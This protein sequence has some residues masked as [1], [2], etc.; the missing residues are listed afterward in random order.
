MHAFARAGTTNNVDMNRNV[1]KICKKILGP[2]SS[3]WMLGEK[4]LKRTNAKCCGNIST[5]VYRYAADNNSRCYRK[6]NVNPLNANPIKWPNTL[7][8]FVGKL[9]TNC[10]SVFGHF[11]NLALK[12][13]IEKLL[14]RALENTG[15]YIK[16]P[17]L[18]AHKWISA[19]TVVCLSRLPNI[20]C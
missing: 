11:V 8:Q 16:R 10:L 3:F 1:F 17:F 2:G 18:K 12:G 19:A 20:R 6:K 9:P 13:L 5:E 7:K 14:P 4:K 15:L